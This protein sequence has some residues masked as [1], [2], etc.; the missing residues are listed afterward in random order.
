MLAEA[1]SIG[2]H[3][4]GQLRQQPVAQFAKQPVSQIPP[5]A[6]RDKLPSIEAIVRE[7]GLNG[8]TA[9]SPG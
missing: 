9:D 3:P 6:L 8:L 1:R 4:A 2:L 7:L 5:D